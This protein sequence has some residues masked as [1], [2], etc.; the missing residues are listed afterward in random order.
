MFCCKLLLLEAMR[1]IEA[2]G[3]WQSLGTNT[4]TA[5]ITRVCAQYLQYVRLLIEVALIS[6]F[7]HYKK[8]VL[9]FPPCIAGELKKSMEK[10]QGPEVT[11]PHDRA[12][13][14]MI[15]SVLVT[16]E[17]IFYVI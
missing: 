2:R 12:L 4:Q 11:V 9:Y 8:R 15:L 6:S 13:L 3:I 5:R 10:S 1:L 7:K 17:I 16:S 14:L